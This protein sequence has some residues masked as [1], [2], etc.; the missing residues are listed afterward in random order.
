MY[1]LCRDYACMMHVLCLDYA[2]FLRRLCLN[3]DIFACT[4]K[5]GARIMKGI[6][7]PDYGSCVDYIYIYIYIHNT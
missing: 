3:D 4:C 5:D 7:M 2:W 6:C 1:G